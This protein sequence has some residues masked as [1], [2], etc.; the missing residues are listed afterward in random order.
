MLAP[1]A[2]CEAAMGEASMVGVEAAGI[3]LDFANA[4]LTLSRRWLRLVLERARVCCVK[5]GCP[6]SGS[7]FALCVDSFL[8]WVAS[9]PSRRRRVFAYADDLAV[10]LRRLFHE[11]PA[12]LLL[13][14][15]RGIVTGL[16]L[17][18]NKSVIVW[19]GAHIRQ[20]RRQRCERIFRRQTGS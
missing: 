18:L 17:R 6:L 2:V 15:R 4:F 3:V 16:F 12:W 1:V 13:L 10:I 11:L 7:L 14:R 8:R 9:A 20:S 5:Q 19:L